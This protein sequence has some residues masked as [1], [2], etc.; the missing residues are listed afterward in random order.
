[1][2]ERVD[3]SGELN[4]PGMVL[5]LVHDRDVGLGPAMEAGQAQDYHIVAL[6]RKP[7][8]LSESLDYCC[9]HQSTPL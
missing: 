5:V 3:A 8:F 2:D 6:V 1:M 7:L 9:S 4:L